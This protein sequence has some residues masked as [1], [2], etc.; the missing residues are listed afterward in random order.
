MLTSDLAMS[1]RRGHRISPRYIQADDPRFL[2][3]AA[4]LIL[5]VKQHRGRRRVDLERAL[6][7]YI[8]VGTDYKIL[9]GMIKL[10]LDRYAFETVCAKDPLELRRA[11]FTKSGAHHPVIADEQLREKLIADVAAELDCTPEEVMESLYADLAGNQKLVAFEDLSAA[12]LLDRY[13]LAQAQAL[14]YRCSEMHLRVEPQEPVTTR[15]LFAEIKAFR[16]IHAIKGN[17]LA[18][19]EVRLSGPV[20][21]FH[22]SQKYGIQMAVFLP[23]LLRYSGWQMR[24]EIDAKTGTAF[25]ELDSRQKNLRSSYLVEEHSPQNLMLAKLVEDWRNLPGDWT[26]QP[27]QEVI[28][29]GETVF[30]PD[31][32]F[33]RAA[34]E[35]IYLE[36][37]GYWTPRHLSERLKEFERAGFQNY[38]IVASEELLCSREAPSQLPPNVFICKKSLNAKELR[39]KIENTKL[40]K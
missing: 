30:I 6:D 11:L 40:A 16:L 34:N 15:S 18:G 3:T 33:Q 26:M 8:G 4:D 12:E 32:I 13:N 10:L 9:R 21:I 24:A 36:M 31:L 1:W 2:Q 19:Y 39:I 29:L 25:F 23:A 14:L 38:L 5:I 20:S 35:I 37:L 7:E 27:S 22:R 17:P 28:D